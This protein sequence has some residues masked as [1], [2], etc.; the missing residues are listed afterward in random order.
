MNVKKLTVVA[1]ARLARRYSWRTTNRMP[2][3]ERRHSGS[4]SSLDVDRRGPAP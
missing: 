2:S 4:G 3:I 1:Q